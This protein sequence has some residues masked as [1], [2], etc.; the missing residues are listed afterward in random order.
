MKVFLMAFFI[1]L[2]VSC[3]DDND[4]IQKDYK[5]EN[6][7]EIVDYIAAQGLDAT[8][9]NSGLYYVIDEVGEGADITSTSDV[10]VK[11]KG[12]F[13]NGSVF[14]QQTETGVSFNLQRTIQ[15][16]IEGIPYFNE[17][18]SGM[19]LIPS[20]LAY[21]S[22]GV[23]GIPGGSVLIFDIEII[24]YDAENR[25]E[26]LAYIEENNLDALESD[27]GLFYVIDELGTGDQPTTESNVTV[28]YKGYYTDDSVFVES[29]VNGGSF[30]LNQFGLLPGFSEGLQYFKEGG[31]G[32]LLMPS[33]LAYGRFGNPEIPV[34]G[35]AVVIFDVELKSV[36]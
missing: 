2:F 16:W 35:G 32:T 36:N 22:E 28:V 11:Y 24:D 12:Y 10:T 3:S 14:D 26:I 33:S 29:E 1:V 21:G 20:H 4:D 6:E 34:P 27:T 31:N 18:G 8:R 19:L 7:Q 9:T 17:G 30:D 23:S 13:T 15:G 25:E 5:A